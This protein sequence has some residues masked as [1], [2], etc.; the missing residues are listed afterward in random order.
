MWEQQKKQNAKERI[1]KNAREK[2][3]KME[4]S[5]ENASA[6]IQ[7]QRNGTCVL[8]F[9]CLPQFQCVC[10]SPFFQDVS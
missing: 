4:I 8:H 1:P 7:M 6:K 9:S 5:K 2:N 10:T 3:E